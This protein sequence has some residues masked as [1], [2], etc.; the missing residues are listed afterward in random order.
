[1]KRIILTVLAALVLTVQSA[2]AM[3][4]ERASAEARFLTDK[5]AY[6]LNLDDYQ[7]QQAYDINFN[8][9]YNLNDASDFYGSY[10]RTRNS[11]LELI[12][13]ALQFRD[14]C[15]LDYFYRPVYVYRNAWTFPIYRRYPRTRFFRPAPPRPPRPGYGFHFEPAGRP[16]A[17]RPNPGRP[18]YN[19][20]G[21]SFGERPD[22][23]NDR[24]QWN[25]RPNEQPG[26]RPDNRPG[27]NAPSQRPGR[28][29]TDYTPGN[30]PGNRPGWNGTGQDRPGFN[31]RPDFN[32]RPS[33]GSRPGNDNRPGFNSFPGNRGNRNDF[34]PG[35]RGN[36]FSSPSRG[37]GRESN[38]TVQMKRVTNGNSFFRGGRM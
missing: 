3:S 15:R 17:P 32:N 10:W 30:R 20:P 19:R 1:M 31:N 6:E 34:Q 36:N 16:L 13:S 33:S 14:F 21:Y 26:N 11:A 7:Y 4:Y 27:Y 37:N 25:N 35:R 2:S 28:P 24:P 12:F 5:M 29:D 9:F 18:G 38:S 23:P 8:Y 22:R